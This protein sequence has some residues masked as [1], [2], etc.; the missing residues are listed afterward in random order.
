MTE[1]NEINESRDPGNPVDRVFPG[2]SAYLA[3]RFGAEAAAATARPLGGASGGVKSGGYGVPTLVEWAS[4]SGRLTRLVL[5]TVRTGGFGHEDRADRARE[6]IRAGDD[7]GTLPRHVRAVDFGVF[8]EDG[9]ALGL[10]HTGEFFFLTEL[11]T[12]EPYARDFAAIS[13]RGRLL[14]LDLERADALASYL[15]ELHREPV[16]HPTY[17]RR[18]LRDLTGSGECLAGVLDSYPNDGFLSPGDLLGIELRALAWRYFLRDRTER[19]RVIHGDF[20][21]WNI[22]FREGVDFTLLDRSR[23]P[24][25]DPADDVAALLVNYLFFALR[26]E[27]SWRG[28]F[29]ELFSRFWERYLALSSDRE[30]AAVLAP[31]LAFRLAVVANPLWYPNESEGTRRGLIRVLDMVL[32]DGSSGF[33]LF[34]PTR[35]KEALS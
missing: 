30:L 12:G 29:S 28:P 35:L 10:A 5:E 21:P 1:P 8:R 13:E 4:P 19:L 26:T 9:A 11:A 33:P 16:S 22:L 25:G 6:V 27:G 14:P 34:E 15:A 7:Y 24:Y 3:K 2:L 31:H 23:G 18:R 20:H 32:G 17:Y